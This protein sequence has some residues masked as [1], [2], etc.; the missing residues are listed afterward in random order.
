MKDVGLMIA[1]RTCGG[2]GVDDVAV[3][4]FYYCCTGAAVTL[5]A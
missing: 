2:Q 5:L 4:V 1:G 3:A